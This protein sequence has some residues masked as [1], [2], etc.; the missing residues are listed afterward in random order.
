MTGFVGQAILS[1]SFML[2]NEPP[3]LHQP[4][5]TVPSKSTTICSTPL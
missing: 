4:I 5:I 1:G 2:P 3:T